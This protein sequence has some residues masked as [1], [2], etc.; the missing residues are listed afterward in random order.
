MKHA[1]PCHLA[2]AG[3]SALVLALTIPARAGTTYQLTKLPTL[4]GPNAV[5]TAMNNNGEIVGYSTTASGATHAVI[6]NGGIATDIDPGIDN[7]GSRALGI[8]STGIVVGA[9]NSGHGFI[10]TSTGTTDLG[11]N[12]YASGI[13]DAGDVVGSTSSGNASEA[14]LFSNGTVTPLGSLPGAQP[15]A[16]STAYAINN[17]REIV[18]TAYFYPCMTIACPNHAFIWKSGSM[19]DLGFPGTSTGEDDAI[20]LAINDAGEA[21][22]NAGRYSASSGVLWSNGTLTQIGGMALAI[23]NHGVIAGSSPNA[24]LWQNGNWVDLTIDPSSPFFGKVTLD[25]AVAINDNGLIVANETV[26]P[27]SG[28]V[29]VYNTYLLTAPVLGLSPNPL[30]FGNQPVGTPSAA[31]SVTVTNNGLTALG[32]ANVTASAQFSQTNDCGNTLTAGGQCSI[33]VTFTPT[34]GGAQVGMV[35]LN[36]GS[37]PYVIHLNGTGTLAA[38]LNASAA[39]APSGSQITLTWTGPVGSSCTPSGGIPGDGWSGTQAASGSIRITEQVAQ[40]VM[41]SI[42]CAVGAQSVGASTQVTW[43][44]TPPSSG[45]SGALDLTLLIMLLITQLHRLRFTVRGSGGSFVR[46]E[47]RIFVMPT[48]QVHTGFG[49]GPRS[50]GEPR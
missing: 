41:Y 3:L 40:V 21:V 2:A 48:A 24:A 44:V 31:R 17:S 50:S 34:A 20:A 4:G 16:S 18:G 30:A 45:G 12:T 36:V 32:V 49:H 19:T 23:N 43:T 25:V 28:D 10:R 37:Q 8:N 26:Y 11:A 42:T 38:S 39:S 15:G 27:S 35:N 6:W 9:T 22:G 14:G 5:A 33:T 46:V 1:T 13:N 47:H 29:F 7:S